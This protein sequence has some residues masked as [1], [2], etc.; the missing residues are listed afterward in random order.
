M[1]I[2]LSPDWWARAQLKAYLCIIRPDNES[3]WALVVFSSLFRKYLLKY[4][5]FNKFYV[6][7]VEK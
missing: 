2:V 7:F 1:L 3:V 5:V 6:K 4:I